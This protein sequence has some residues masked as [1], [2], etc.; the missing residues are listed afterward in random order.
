MKQQASYPENKQGGETEVYNVYSDASKN[1]GVWG[2][3]HH[4]TG[5]LISY[6]G[7]LF[8]NGQAVLAGLPFDIS[9]L[10]SPTCGSALFASSSV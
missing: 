3:T 1:G 8:S 5:D 10:E 4:A 9:P 7:T 6:Y 2:V